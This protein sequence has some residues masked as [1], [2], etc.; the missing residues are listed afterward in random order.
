VEVNVNR[1]VRLTTYLAALVAVAPAAW[2]ETVQV[3][4]ERVNLTAEA[5]SDS[6]VMATVTRGTVLE[7]LRRE[8]QW[9]RVATPGSGYAAYIPR[10]AVET[11]VGGA[12]PPG[13]A[14]PP[15]PAPASGPPRAPAAPSVGATPAAVAPVTPTPAEPEASP[16]ASQPS[17]SGGSGEKPVSFGVHGS[18]ATD[19]V[20]F[21]VGGRVAFDL[22]DLSGV[23]HL[24]GLVTFD[25]FFGAGASG[26]AGDV[27]VSADADAIQ[28]DAYAT[29]L[30][31][32]ERARPYVGAGVSYFRV[33]ASASAS[34][35]GSPDLSVSASAS[36]TSLAI[37]GGVKLKQR[38]FAE[39][40]YH[41]GDASHLTFSAGVQF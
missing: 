37:L 31:E 8:G 22:S 28:V 25:Y 3:T 15:S 34:V 13:T 17:S 26:T 5:S 33:S 32:G 18:F 39:A 12:L 23:E 6:R 1:T 19:D 29:Y 27:A 11:G 20:D 21:G 30:F 38:F 7:V 14:A 24:G 35:P 4:A 10:T 9:I 36:H 2:A 40:R 16:R 41:F